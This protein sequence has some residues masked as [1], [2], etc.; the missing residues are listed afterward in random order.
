MDDLAQEMPCQGVNIQAE[1]G[2]LYSN[3][4]QVN[5][6]PWFH[7]CLVYESFYGI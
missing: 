6:L 3:L 4:T 7:I 2:G 1:L 5:V